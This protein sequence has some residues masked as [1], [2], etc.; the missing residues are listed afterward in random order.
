[1]SVISQ[2]SVELAE[3]DRQFEA[4]S[5]AVRTGRADSSPL[6]GSE[7][8]N[9]RAYLEFRLLED[10]KN[11]RRAARGWL[12]LEPSYFFVVSSLK[13][14]VDVTGDLRVGQKV[15]ED[16]KALAAGASCT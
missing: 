8:S 6:F 7:L 13:R 1:M 3:L 15:L 16:M 14:F 12:Y 9:R 10:L 4:W 5:E 2:E 11:V